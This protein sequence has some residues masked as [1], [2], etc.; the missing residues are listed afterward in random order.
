[1]FSTGA[2]FLPIKRMPTII[3][4]V[5]R[6]QLWFGNCQGTVSDEPLMPSKALEAT[7]M[8]NLATPVFG[9]DFS[10]S[11]C[12]SMEMC[13]RVRPYIINP[14]HEKRTC[15]FLEGVFSSKVPVLL[16]LS[17]RDVSYPKLP[18]GN[19]PLF[20]LCRH[21]KN[22][23]LPKTEP[24]AVSPRKKWP[25]LLA[26]RSGPCGF[27]RT[28]MS[29]LESTRESPLIVVPGPRCPWWRNWRIEAAIHGFSAMEIH[30]TY[31]ANHQE[32][33]GHA[34]MKHAVN[35]WLVVQLMVVNL[36]TIQG[37]CL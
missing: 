16:D 25:V 22:R 21:V 30:P 15:H 14:S 37:D 32:L 8:A 28:Y 27:R 12:W 5:W 1:M 24:L 11:S 19:P 20:V 29:H 13:K 17:L 23:G 33:Q 2:E 9:N 31:E 7:G 36:P 4:I 26:W 3:D 6:R 35:K 18:G 34:T 10:S